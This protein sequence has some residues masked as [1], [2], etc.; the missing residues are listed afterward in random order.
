MTSK[1]RCTTRPMRKSGAETAGNAIAH[2]RRLLRRAWWAI[3][4]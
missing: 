3:R 2:P 1:V 4:R